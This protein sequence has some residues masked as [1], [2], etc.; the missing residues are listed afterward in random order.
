MYNH[1]VSK[2]VMPLWIFLVSLGRLLMVW[3]PR[4]DCS[5][6]L[7]KTSYGLVS[8]D[9]LLMVWYPRI[10]CLWSGILG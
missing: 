1:I 8:S 7:G 2:G 9:R 4:E 5:G 6:I 3:Y 10:N